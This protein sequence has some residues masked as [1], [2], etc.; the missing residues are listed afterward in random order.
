MPNS[1]KYDSQILKQE[2]APKS[3]IPE[4]GSVYDSQWFALGARYSGVDNLRKGLYTHL[5]QHYREEVEVELILNSSSSKTSA[6]P[7]NK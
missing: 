4:W 7:S 3:V 5:D 2:R 6:N 1:V